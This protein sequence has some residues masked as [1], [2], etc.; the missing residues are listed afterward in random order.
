MKLPQLRQRTLLVAAALALIALASISVRPA[1][2]GLA[3]FTNPAGGG[4]AA[5]DH[6]DF[7]A[8]TVVWQL[9]PA[10]GSNISGGR[11]VGEVMQT[12]FDTWLAAPNAVLQVS[13]GADLGDTSAG[14][15]PS[16]TSNTNLVCFVCS[17]DFSKDSSTLAVTIT[18]TEDRPNTADGHGGRSRFVGQLLDA[19]ILFNPGVQFSTGGGN[20][21]DLQ[22]VATHEVGHFFGLDHSGVVRAMMFPFAPD[23]EVTLSY[24]DVSAISQLYPKSSPDFPGGTITGRVTMGG[25]P[26]FGAHVFAQSVTSDIPVGSGIRK[27]PIGTLTLPDGTYRI[28]G[29]PADQYIVIAEPLDDPERNADVS[30][31]PRA[32]G[33]SSVQTN[34]TTRWH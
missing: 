2:S 12:S 6:W 28:T 4:A 34:F 30:G 22:T 13:R 19:D 18:T 8:F 10:T 27:T 5:P 7:T 25:A 14:F 33:Q 1:F 11:S 20:G 24:D 26:I 9:N 29:V 21:Q 15:N 17:G 23:F 32:F 31:Y 16:S 3:Q